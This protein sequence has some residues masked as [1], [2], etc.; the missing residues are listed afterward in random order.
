MELQRIVDVADTV[1]ESI[2]LTWNSLRR[3]GAARAAPCCLGGLEGNSRLA[4]FSVWR[5]RF[6]P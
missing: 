4:L 5:S 2:Q 6:C 1:R 3:C